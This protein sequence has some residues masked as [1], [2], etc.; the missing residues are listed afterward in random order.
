MDVRAGAA[1]KVGDVLQTRWGDYPITSIEQH[2]R[3]GRRIA[4]SGSW[5]MTVR[6]DAE[7]RIVGQVREAA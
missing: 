6:H 2:P 1:L 3:A 5:G 4:R 7:Y